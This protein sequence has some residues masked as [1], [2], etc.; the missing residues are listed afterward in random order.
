MNMLLG[1][2]LILT[3]F[4]LRYYVNRAW[5]NRLNEYGVHVF[6]NYSDAVMFKTC[7][8]CAKVIGVLLII[9]GAGYFYAG[10][11]S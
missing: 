7:T 2:V 6:K 11:I 10:L 3:G 9:V 1:S 4:G 5:F 8:K